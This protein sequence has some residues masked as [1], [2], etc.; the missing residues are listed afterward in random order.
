MG[1]PASVPKCIQWA[2]V[3]GAVLVKMLLPAAAVHLNHRVSIFEG[4]LAS[5][6]LDI[7]ILAQGK[8]LLT[9][10]ITRVAGP[11]RT[12]VLPSV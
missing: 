4:L 7:E 3:I 6:V 8:H 11:L 1:C 12:T 10:L 9:H 2:I 5:L